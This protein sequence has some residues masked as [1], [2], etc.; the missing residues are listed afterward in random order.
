M[1]VS[2]PQLVLLH[3]GPAPAVDPAGR[4]VAVSTLRVD[5]ADPALSTLPG[6]ARDALARLP[7][8]PSGA[9]FALAALGT[10]A[11]TFAQALALELLGRDRR[12]S[13]V[14]LVSDAALPAVH[15]GAHDDRLVAA[16]AAWTPPDPAMLP[17]QRCPV[18]GVDVADWIVRTATATTLPPPPPAVMAL[19][20]KH[21]GPQR[22][23]IVCIPGA[24]ASVVALLDLA[25]AAHPQATVYGMQPRGLD[26]LAPPCATVETAADAVAAQIAQVL[27]HG[28]LRLVGHSFGGWIAFETALRLRAAGR[29]IVGLDLLDSRPPD[30]AQ[31]YREWD[32]LAVLLHWT[33]LTELSAER[34]LG[35]DAEA[36]RLLPA[37]ARLQAVHRGMREAGLLPPRSEPSSIVGALRMFAACMRTQYAPSGTY[38][39]ALRVVHLR[40]PALDADGDERAAEA[41][42]AGWSRHALRVELLRGD[43]NHMTGIRGAHARALADRLG[44]S[45]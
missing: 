24:G 30:P 41:R 4:G 34:R 40:N 21:G 27:P 7:A 5:E 28:P 18:A 31:A 14:A 29:A 42:H 22:A 37:A 19:P 45:A 32:D 39:G 36:L 23:P 20:L 2:A 17:V 26:G 16:C 11:S 25:Q 13:C 44:L 1:I 15:A 12:V 6:M 9:G 8:D 38:D 35:I 10:C 43:G 3:G 33:R